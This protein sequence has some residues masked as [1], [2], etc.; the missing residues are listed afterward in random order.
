MTTV[1]LDANADTVNHWVY[2]SIM[3]FTLI[4]DIHL[5]DILIFKKD[6]ISEK[7]EKALKKFRSLLLSQPKSRLE[8]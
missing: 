5:Q 4:L 2:A 3:N 8:W 6:E 1:R 7:K